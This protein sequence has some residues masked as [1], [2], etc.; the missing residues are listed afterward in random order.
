MLYTSFFSNKNN[1]IGVIIGIARITPK[2]IRQ[3]INF[4]PSYD[5]VRAMK[6][7]EL[8]QKQYTE[9]Y[10]KCLDEDKTIPIIA[11]N[12]KEYENDEKRHLI[13]CCYCKEGFCHR[14]LLRKY[15]QEKYNLK[16]QELPEEVN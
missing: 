6:A 7:G 15:L 13:F 11:E 5:L 16:I 3:L 12:L 14:H 1:K 8:S 2:S 9:Y 4:A 10:L